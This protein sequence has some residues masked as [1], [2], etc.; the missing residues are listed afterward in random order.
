MHPERHLGEDALADA[1]ASFRSPAALA[2]FQPSTTF[3]EYLWAGCVWRQPVACWRPVVA[4][5]Q[6]AD[7]RV[8]ARLEGEERA[9]PPGLHRA[10]E[11]R[12]KVAPPSVGPAARA[13]AQCAGSCRRAAR[14]SA[15][16]QR[17]MRRNGAVMHQSFLIK[18]RPP[19]AGQSTAAQRPRRA[20]ATAGLVVT[21]TPSGHICVLLWRRSS[22]TKPENSRPGAGS[23]EDGGPHEREGAA[24]DAQRRAAQL[25]L[26]LTHRRVDGV[27]CSSTPMST[28]SIWPRAAIAW[29][30]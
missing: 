27:S 20:D 30:P 2:L 4:A 24:M 22:S 16:R 10:G 9:E 29:P 18:S 1:E 6:V 7:W 3:I 5:E 25:V 17:R 23:S 13:A 28:S 15:P 19:V 26:D 21:V 8:C 12:V 11:L 14:A